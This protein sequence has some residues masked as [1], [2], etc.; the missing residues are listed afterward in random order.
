MSAEFNPKPTVRWTW[1]VFLIGSAVHAIVTE[2]WWWIPVW[3][4]AWF[5]LL[6]SWAA[7]RAVLDANR[8]RGA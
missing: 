8:E 6:L 1:W 4:V 3:F 2:Q 5:A 7:V